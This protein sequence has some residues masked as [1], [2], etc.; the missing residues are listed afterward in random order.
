MLFPNINKYILASVV[1]I[2]LLFVLCLYSLSI[3]IK[4]KENFNWVQHTYEVINET[5]SLMYG[6]LGAE[7]QVRAFII[8]NDKSNLPNFDNSLINAEEALDTLLQLTHDNSIQQKKLNVLKNLIEDRKSLFFENI[9]HRKNRPEDEF[10]K[11]VTIKGDNKM[12]AIKQLVASIK[13]EELGLLKERK[14]YNEKLS[15]ELFWLT[16]VLSLL[17]LVTGAFAIFYTSRDI[18]YRQ[19]NE[20]ELKSLNKNKNKFF[21]IIS[22][23]LKG[24]AGGIM[25]LSEFLLNDKFEKDHKE[26]A[27]RLSIAAGNHYKLLDN[28]LTWSR[29]QM[30]KLEL[31]PIVLDI[32]KMVAD[33][34]TSIVALANEKAIEITNQIPQGIQAW[35]DYNM[36]ETVIRNLLQNAVK[37]TPHNG[38]IT[39]SSKD[40]GKF[41][42][43]SIGISEEYLNRLF[44]IESTFSLRGTDDEEGTGMGLLLCKEFVEKNGGK[45]MAVS[46]EGKGATFSFI[47]PKTPLI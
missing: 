44:R 22:H 14:E 12:E 24:P 34:I 9:V 36:I 45:I 41:I 33:S 15:S 28:L 3:Y 30:G 38:K 13:N 1:S 23:D 35:G 39:I 21:S 2:G 4:Q 32:N 6:L 42:E 46:K 17:S 29:S 43:L 10:F 16:I 8:T 7:S 27:L 31:Y 20:E 47:L 18:N 40:L 25:K 19:K 37:F 5:E 26:I 11:E